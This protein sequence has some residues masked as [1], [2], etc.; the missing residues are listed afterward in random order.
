MNRYTVDSVE[1]SQIRAAAA[2]R[3]DSRSEG[4]SPTAT[5][6]ASRP[7]PTPVRTHPGSLGSL[8]ASGVEY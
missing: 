3:A 5:P 7:L 4:L 2:G 1:R 8:D 6:S